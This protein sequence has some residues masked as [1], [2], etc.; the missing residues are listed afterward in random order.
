MLLQKNEINRKVLKKTEEACEHKENEHG[1]K[2]RERRKTN[3]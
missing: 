2:E 3:N 1:D